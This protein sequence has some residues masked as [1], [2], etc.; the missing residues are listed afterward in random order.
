MVTF[1]ILA[2]S[3]TTTLTSTQAG[4]LFNF[5][6][7]SLGFL[8]ADCQ[9]T[10]EPQETIIIIILFSSF[11]LSETL[12]LPVCN[13][14]KFE[15]SHSLFCSHFNMQVSTVTSKTTYRFW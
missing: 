14:V 6:T 13:Q 15:K 4:C 9:Q 1:Q 7:M 5:L 11:L 2:K 12:L 8:V 3:L 10:A